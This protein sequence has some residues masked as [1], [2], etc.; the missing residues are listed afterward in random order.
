M[1][2]FKKL[3]IEPLVSINLPIH[4]DIKRTGSDGVQSY[5]E[6]SV[7][8]ITSSGSLAFT[9][10]IA[11]ECVI[12]QQI[13]EIYFSYNLGMSMRLPWYMAG[14]TYYPFKKLR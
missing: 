4:R 8:P 2:I 10:K 5:K 12:K 9:P 1:K 14:I 11:Y 3:K 6:Q 7:K 13:F